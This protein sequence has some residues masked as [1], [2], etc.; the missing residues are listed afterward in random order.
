MIAGL[1]GRGDERL[2]CLVTRGPWKKVVKVAKEGGG[3]SWGVE[4]GGSL[5]PDFRTQHT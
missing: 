1:V 3:R 5:Q 2:S 4:A